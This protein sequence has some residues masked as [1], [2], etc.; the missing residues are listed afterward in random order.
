MLPTD[1]E[2]LIM[3]F[4]DE[5]EIWRKRMNVNMVLKSAFRE[6]RAR[7]EIESLLLDVL[8]DMHPHQ[9][10]WFRL[11]TY[12]DVYDK[13]LMKIRNKYARRVPRLL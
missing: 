5:H 8:T 4:H 13:R 6:W 7:V 2:N 10:E 1:L 3:S 12:L 9:V 11:M